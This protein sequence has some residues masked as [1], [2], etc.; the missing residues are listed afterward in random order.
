MQLWRT[1]GKQ[2][3]EAALN[4]QLVEY[5]VWNVLGLTNEVITGNGRLVG[6]RV[7]EERERGWRRD[8][9]RPHRWKLYQLSGLE[10]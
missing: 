8:S 6:I 5:I 9:E 3:G 10:R 1:R 2:T 7:T 4:S